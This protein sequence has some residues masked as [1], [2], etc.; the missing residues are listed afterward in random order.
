MRREHGWKS[1][2]NRVKLKL[3]DNIWKRRRGGV[4]NDIEI[5]CLASG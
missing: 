4:D 2:R 3:G 1:T 5:S